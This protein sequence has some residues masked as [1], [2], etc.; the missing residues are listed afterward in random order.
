MNA[1][2]HGYLEVHPRHGDHVR[3]KLDDLVAVCPFCH[4]V[5]HCGAGLDQDSGV[6]VACP[7]I[8]QQDL[9]L[10]CNA[11]AAASAGE[12]VTAEIVHRLWAQLER[13]RI[14]VPAAFKVQRL[15]CGL[16][17]SGL[18]ALRDRAPDLY[19]RRALGIGGLR[20]LPDRAVFAEAVAYWK[21]VAWQSVSE[22]QEVYRQWLR[23]PHE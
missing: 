23:R 16:L 21:S 12:D 3:W 15:S 10:L 1:R 14:P 19:E 13:G 22:W 11:M 4:E 20:Y 5:L 8:T 17:A 18:L 6:I 9:C 2:C 7:W